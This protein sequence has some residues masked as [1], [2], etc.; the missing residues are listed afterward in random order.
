MKAYRVGYI[1]MVSFLLVLFVVSMTLG[2]YPAPKGPKAPEYPKY[3][4]YSDSSYSRDPYGSDYGYDSYSNKMKQYE[5]DKEDYEAEQRSFVR[6][7]VIPYVRNVFVFWI[8]IL[9]LFQVVGL[10][11]ARMGADL[12]GGAYSF[13][14]VIAVLFGPFTGLIWFANSTIQSFSGRSEE[15]VI[16]DPLWQALTVVSLLGVIGLTVV[17]LILFGPLRVVRPQPKPASPPPAV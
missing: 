6:K 17:G 1:L 15:Q 12:V 13:S 14:G 3:D 2:F 8:I 11:L 16:L 4:S 5:E 10:F 7:K 9:G